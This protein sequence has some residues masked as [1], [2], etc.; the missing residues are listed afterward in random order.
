MIKFG[1][2]AKSLL[3][4]YIESL[5]PSNTWTVITFLLEITPLSYF[6]IVSAFRA[7]KS[8]PANLFETF[9]TVGIFERSGYFC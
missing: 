5:S 6:V 9:A 8:E 2:S 4:I 1:I 3:I 7:S